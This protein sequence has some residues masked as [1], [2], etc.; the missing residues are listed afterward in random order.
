MMQ[1]TADV[2]IVAANYNNGQYLKAFLDSVL[3]STVMPAQLIIVDDGSRDESVAI[4]KEYE[5]HPNSHFIYS[6]SNEGFAHALNKGLSAVKTKYV[7]RADP[8]DIL[9]PM[10]IEKQYHF[11]EENPDLC[12]VGSNVVYFQGQP[13]KIINKSNFPLRDKDI[14]NTYKKGEH[15]L[16]HPTVMIRSEVFKDIQYRQDVVPAEDYDFFARLIS[17][18]YKFRNIDEA[19]YKMRIHETSASSNLER[20][21]I[22]KTY[23]LRSE[24]FGV[25]SSSIRVLGYYNYIQNYRKYLMERNSVKRFYFLTVSILCYPGKLFKRIRKWRS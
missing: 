16:Q 15:G 2:A 21:T 20:E 23:Q 9:M 19:L 25:K 11:L 3:S 18:G 13:D 24:I 7:L 10:K 1:E 12:G 4:L 17:K 22:K 14:R 8:D 5:K 6:P